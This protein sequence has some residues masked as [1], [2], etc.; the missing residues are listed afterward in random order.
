MLDFLYEGKVN[1]KF[2]YVDES[3]L[4]MGAVFNLYRHAVALNKYSHT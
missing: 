3:F 2:Y 4:N 1:S